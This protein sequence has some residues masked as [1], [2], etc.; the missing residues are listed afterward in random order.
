MMDL[1]QPK[2]VGDQ[3]LTTRVAVLQNVRRVEK[4]GVTEAADR[5][6]LAIRVEHESAEVLLVK[7]L[8][9]STG[10][11]ASPRGGE[12]RIRTRGTCSS[13]HERVR[14]IGDEREFESFRVIAGDIDGENGVIDTRI[15]SNQIEQRPLS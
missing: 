11:I 4:L 10:D 15:D 2:S 1:T 9:H 13:A 8:H 7:P 12:H 3:R 6:L 5:A 14:F